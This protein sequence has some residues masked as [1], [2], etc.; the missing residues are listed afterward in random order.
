MHSD[1]GGSADIVLATFNAGYAHCSLG[2]RCLLANLGPLRPRARLL[3]FD[4]R[5]PPETAAARIAALS[6]RLCGVGVYIWNVR[7]ALRLAAMLKAAP[8]PPVVVV[9]GPELSHGLGH[10]P[11]PPAA[12]CV[13]AGEG[14]PV[15]RSLAE[16][17]LA[18]Q[19]L[20]PL[21]VAGAADLASVAGP[22]AEYSE[23]DLAHRI[24]YLESS[25]GCPHACDYCL[26]AAV[27]GVRWRPLDEV[28]SAW[29]RLIGRGAR[30]LKIVDRTFNADTE[31]AA[32]LLRFLAQRLPADGVVQVEM[33]P[34]PPPPILADAFRQFRPGALRVEVGIQTFNPDVARRIGRAPENGGAA[35]LL[36][37]LRAASAVVHADLIAG[38]P[39][40]TPA[41][42]AAG[43]DRVVAME[44]DELQINVLKRLPGAPIGRHDSAWGMRY[45]REPPYAVMS[46][47]TWPAEAMARL[48]R[49]AR[50]WELCHN[51]GR[52]RRTLPML[53]ASGAERSPFHAFA[54]FSDGLYQRFGRAHSLPADELAKALLEH[55]VRDIGASR[56]IVLGA[57]RSDF[58][59]ARMPAPRWLCAGRARRPAASRRCR[60]SAENTRRRCPFY[61]QHGG[62]Q[63][64]DL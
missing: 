22:E 53:W 26:S 2:L 46:T 6:P 30:R 50:Y 37:A 52:F 59:A 13:V 5:T 45:D 34:R 57:L 28:V 29:D 9:G 21:V 25:R 19:R 33:T 1:N 47:S 14:E 10:L 44:P 23:S 51:R 8:S 35:A 62:D 49:M 41:S 17:I 40:E 20:P 12:D 11:V 36:R 42:F 16:S 39:G 54:R 56:E 3:E 48:Q 18:G 7:P 38:L 61:N 24:V 64:P 27:P 55:L 43:F 15:V 58:A 63:Y 4:G 32:G 31:R 60:L